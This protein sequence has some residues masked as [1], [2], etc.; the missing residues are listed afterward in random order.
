MK[1]NFGQKFLLNFF[2]SAS[3][4]VLLISCSSPPNV[5]ENFEKKFGKKVEKI[6]AE[7]AYPHQ[8]TT[9]TFQSRAPTI[10]EVRA[11][12]SSS[13]SQQAYYAYV[14]VEQFG[15][16]L[17]QNYLPNGEVYER[18][19]ENISENAA[20][21]I[22]DIAYNTTLFPPFRRAGLE[23]DRIAIPEKDASGVKTEMAEKPYL[24][25][26]NVSLQKAVDKINAEKTAED[27]EISEALVAEQKQLRR[28]QKMLKI[29]GKDS[30]ELAELEKK[31]EKKSAETSDKK[32][33]KNSDAT[34]NKTPTPDLKKD[35]QEDPKKTKN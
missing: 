7:R 12:Y 33:D 3:L 10:E 25:A 29:F 5:N 13:A 2:L 30:V 24:L 19:R 31:P 18:S 15:D 27:I 32:T 23:F 21:N 17:P 28:K 14:D 26:G 6:K 20:R 34:E 35:P 9:E 8:E 22:F 4:L 11:E 16:K 1:I